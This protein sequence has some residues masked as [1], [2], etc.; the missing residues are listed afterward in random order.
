MV[1]CSSLGVSA[2]LVTGVAIVDTTFATTTPPD[3]AGATAPPPETPLS[4]DLDA[5]LS[6]ALGDR[7]GGIA[8]LS[9]HDGVT[10]KAV[11]GDR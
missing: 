5:L 3:E 6:D 1:I 2:W 10:T 4:G 8:A 11:A 9:V 7:D